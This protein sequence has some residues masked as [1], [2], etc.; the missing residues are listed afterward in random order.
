MKR[1]VSLL[2]L[3]GQQL[4]PFLSMDKRYAIVKDDVIVCRV[5]RLTV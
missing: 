4:M 2:K 5:I 3:Q 1:L